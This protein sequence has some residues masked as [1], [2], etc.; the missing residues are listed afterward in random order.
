MQLRKARQTNEQEAPVVANPFNFP[1][2]NI[3]KYF[4]E[5][6]GKMFIQE[7]GFEPLM[8]LCK[9]IWTLVLYRRW[10]HFGIIPKEPAIVPKK[11]ICVKRWIYH[12]IKRYISDK[13]IKEP[14]TRKAI[15][16]RALKNK[17]GGTHHKVTT[18][19]R[20]IG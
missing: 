13:K 15:Q 10:E 20:L 8:L 6:Q 16:L 4:L 17:E 7:R 14:D 3:E 19:S 11:L 18:M 1:N 5:L 2:P 9:E 12:S